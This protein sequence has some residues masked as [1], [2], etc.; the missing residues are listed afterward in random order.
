[1]KTVT[2][3]SVVA[4]EVDLI[5]SFTALRQPGGIGPSHCLGDGNVLAGVRQMPMGEIWECGDGEYISMSNELRVRLEQPLL[6]D[7]ELEL[8][9]EKM[10]VR[11]FYTK[12]PIWLRLWRALTC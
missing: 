3:Y 11:E 5:D 2:L 8:E 12:A 6:A 10:D 1:M 7:F 4:H 9:M